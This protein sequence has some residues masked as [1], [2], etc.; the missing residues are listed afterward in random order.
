MPAVDHGAVVA[1]ENY[2][3]SKNEF[4][5]YL[6]YNKIVR[7]W[8]VAFGVGG[9]ALFL[10]N[11]Q[12]A[13]RLAETGQLRFVSI[14]FLIGA[15][16]QVGG[17]VINKISNWYVYRGSIDGAYRETRRYKFFKWWVLQYWVDV[18]LDI[19]AIASFGIATWHLLTLFG[20]G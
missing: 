15:G 10:I 3:D 18:V 12:L 4:A 7:S 11:E 20:S 6:E 1:H 19:S 14:L 16:S 9:P 5:A 13:R 8:F 17:A 2:A